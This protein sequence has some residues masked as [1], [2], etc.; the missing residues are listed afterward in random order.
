MRETVKNGGRIVVVGYVA[1]SGVWHCSA[2]SVGMGNGK[3]KLSFHEQRHQNAKR[4]AEC[5][6]ENWLRRM[7]RRLSEPPPSSSHVLHASYS[8]PDFYKAEDISEKYSRAPNWPSRRRI[9][10]PDLREMSAVL[11]GPL[12]K[13]RKVM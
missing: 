5:E 4:P 7:A 12:R 1:A 8:N 3:R 10:I 2:L 11:L 13:R 6:P 9:S